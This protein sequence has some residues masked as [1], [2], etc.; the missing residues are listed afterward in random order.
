MDHILFESN[1]GIGIALLPDAPKFTIVA[2]TN[3]FANYFAVEKEAAIG[4]GFFELLFKNSDNLDSS[5]QELST[6]LNYTIQHKSAHHIF[7]QFTIA[8]T[9]KG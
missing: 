2:V 1:P 3:D 8:K 6:S 9:F 4:K 5:S 7:H